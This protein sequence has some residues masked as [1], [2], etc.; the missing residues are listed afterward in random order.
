[1]QLLQDFKLNK[2]LNSVKGRTRKLA[3]VYFPGLHWKIGGTLEDEATKLDGEDVWNAISK[4][5]PARSEI[6]LNIDLPKEEEGLNGMT[7]YEGIALR[8][9]DM[10]LIM[11]VPNSSW[12]KPPELDGKPE[13]FLKKVKYLFVLL[14][15]CLLQQNRKFF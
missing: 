12:F 4:G 6:L 14:R 5:E 9:G 10:K 13:N 2:T 7:N 11:H 3:N 1:M 15:K 8:S